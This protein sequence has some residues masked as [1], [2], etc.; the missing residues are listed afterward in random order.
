M[1]LYLDFWY[2]V[3]FDC[4]EFYLWHYKVASLQQTLTAVLLV[5]ILEEQSC[6]DEIN[7]KRPR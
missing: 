3:Q 5:I 2:I 7:K 4:T 1:S 6:S